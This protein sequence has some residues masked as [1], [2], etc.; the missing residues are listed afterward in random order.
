MGSN[1]IEF[2]GVGFVSE[3]RLRHPQHVGSSEAALLTWLATATRYSGTFHAKGF[4][5]RIASKQRQFWPGK[6]PADAKKAA[7]AAL[8]SFE[9]PVFSA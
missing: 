1:L 6:R 8:Q 2:T 4:Q 5:P 9:C 3:S 7:R